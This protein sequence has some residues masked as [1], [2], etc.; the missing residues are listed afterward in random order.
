MP[1]PQPS[2]RGS[3]TARRNSSSGGDP[4]A[5]R[6]LAPLEL[7]C[8]IWASPSQTIDPEDAVREGQVT[9]TAT[10]NTRPLSS[11]KSMTASRGVLTISLLTTFCAANTTIERMDTMQPSSPPS[12]RETANREVSF[13][14]TRTRTATV[15]VLPGGIIR[16]KS[17]ECGRLRKPSGFEVS[18]W[19][20]RERDRGGDSVKRR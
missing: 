16:S 17:G 18:T 11:P 14:P 5:F 15:A 8:V 20:H 4:G 10:A 3:A 6:A 19:Q 9:S 2:L 13:M 7:A 12:L 1:S